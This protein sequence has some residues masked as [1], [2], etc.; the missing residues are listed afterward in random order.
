M[1]TPPDVIAISAR[2]E[3]TLTA[4]RADLLVS[5]RG[6]S[7]VTGDAALHKAKEVAK[8][9]QDLVAVGMAAADV[10]LEDVEAE[11]SSGLLGRSSA[12][13]Y[14]LRLRCPQLDL[15]PDMLGIVTTSKNAELAHI[16]WR[17]PDDAATEARWLAAAIR[18]ANLKAAA[19]AAAL[20]A[21]LVGVHR[22]HVEPLG[23]HAPQ[24]FAASFGGGGAPGMARKSVDLGVPLRS[25][26]EAGVQVSVEYRIEGFA[27]VSE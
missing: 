15:L 2:H 14:R 25:Q 16:H 27:P 11:V 20:G 9:V 23:A 4:D 13:T 8:L 18:A 7:L 17:Y 3:Q 26:K 10:V 22:L 6:T 24:M 12:A 1:S 5:V 19:A 21:R